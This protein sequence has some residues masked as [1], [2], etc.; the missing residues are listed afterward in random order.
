[1][2]IKELLADKKL[3]KLFVAIFTL[4]AGYFGLNEA[5]NHY[6]IIER[7][8]AVIAEPIPLPTPEPVRTVVKTVRA[9][10]KDWK[11]V[12]N[13]ICTDLVKQG[14]KEHRANYHGGD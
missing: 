3:R 13:S 1:M 4:I 11:P 12:I 10:E 14:M 9:P 2:T 6:T 8:E 5:S 7:S